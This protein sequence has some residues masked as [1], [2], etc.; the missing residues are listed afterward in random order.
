M[1]GRRLENGDMSRGFLSNIR[2]RFFDSQNYPQQN[3][4]ETSLPANY[5]PAYQPGYEV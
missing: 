1:D 2:D 4:Y 3:P 5:Y